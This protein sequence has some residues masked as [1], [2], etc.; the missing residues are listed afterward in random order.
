TFSRFNNSRRDDVKTGE[1]GLRASFETGPVLHEL[2][3]A[4]SLY[5]HK[6]K[7]AWAM[8]SV[9]ESNLYDPV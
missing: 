4:A 2:V 1:L 3:A 5:D 9:Q 6:E 7:N 8:G